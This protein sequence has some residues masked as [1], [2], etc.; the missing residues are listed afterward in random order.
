MFGP[1]LNTP[2]FHRYQADS[3]Y[4]EFYE[5]VQKF[6]AGKTSDT[7][8]CLPSKAG[9]N[10]VARRGVP[11]PVASL[12]E[13]AIAT[14]STKLARLHYQLKNA[15]LNTKVDFMQAMR[16]KRLGAHFLTLMTYEK[17]D[18]VDPTYEKRDGLLAFLVDGSPNL[19][20]LH[21]VVHQTCYKE[22][23]KLLVVEDVPLCAKF[24][25][26]ALRAA[27]IHCETLHSKLHHKQ[28][29]NLIN[30]FNNKK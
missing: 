6:L 7:R 20:A 19:R 22:A 23:G 21:S 25:E 2:P 8:G 3:I 14:C 24:Y 30:D 29:Q 28:C 26:D 5:F 4:R 13:M 18:P 27:W 10:K 9:P 1:V 15:G 12:R 11:F 17:R 16:E